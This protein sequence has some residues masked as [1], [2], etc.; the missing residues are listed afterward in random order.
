MNLQMMRLSE[1]KIQNHVS[2]VVILAFLLLTSNALAEESLLDQYYNDAHQAFRQGNFP[3]AKDQ[4]IKLLKIRTDIPEAHNLLG[5]VYD[6][7]GN[8][9]MASRHFQTALNLNP[10]FLEARSNLAL[11][12]ISRGNLEGALRLVHQDFKEPDVHF[13]V[14]TALRRKKTYRKALDYALKITQLFPEYPFAHLYAGIEL[15]F[16]GELQQAREHYTKAVALTENNPK[17]QT[18]AKF[19]LASTLAKEGNYAT[20]VPMLEEIIRANAGDIDARLELGGIYLK[21]GK[22]EDAARIAAEAISFGPEERRTHFLLANALSRLG[23][24]QEA[25][26]HFAVFLDLEK[27]QNRSESDKPAIYAKSRD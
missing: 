23:K 6:R 13:L 21:L 24:Q 27:K 16:L 1:K 10:D 7:L 8:A 15:Q 26:K 2:F 11:H 14:V 9:A 3:K 4:L 5:V 12:L 18:A 25:E 17:V 20:A 19:G 22:Y